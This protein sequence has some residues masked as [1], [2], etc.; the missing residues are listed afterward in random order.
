LLQAG[1]GVYVVNFD[2]PSSEVT[3]ESVVNSAWGDENIPV[4]LANVPE[5]AVKAM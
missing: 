5:F 3:F 1:K 4:S 2:V